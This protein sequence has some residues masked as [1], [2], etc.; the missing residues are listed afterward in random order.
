[1]ADGWRVTGQ[2]Q[3]T[4]L[5]PGGTF[6]DVIEVTYAL[7]SGTVGSVRVPKA[8]Y[9]SDNVARLIEAEVAELRNVEN[10]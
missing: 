9:T 7:D 1:M 6:Q 4:D 3:T 2:R 8:Q 10:L 5:G